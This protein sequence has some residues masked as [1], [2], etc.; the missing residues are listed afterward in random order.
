MMEHLKAVIS[1]QRQL[2]TLISPQKSPYPWI[3]DIL[4]IHASP[5]SCRTR[6]LPGIQGVKSPYKQNLGNDTS[7]HFIIDVIAHLIQKEGENWSV[8]GKSYI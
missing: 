8:Y 2:S 4:V 1:L 5:W 7:P 3:V 6:I